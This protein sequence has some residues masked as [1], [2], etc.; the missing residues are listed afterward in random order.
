MPPT[1]LS[2]VE[3]RKINDSLL[4]PLQRT[5]LPEVTELEPEEGWAQW[6]IATKLGDSKVKNGTEPTERR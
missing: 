1:Q 3:A 5:P 6:D 2:L 4:A